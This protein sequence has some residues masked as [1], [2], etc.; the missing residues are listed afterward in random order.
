M[1][2]TINILEVASE[3]AHEKLIKYSD[4]LTEYD[5]RNEFPNGVEV[6]EY[7]IITYTEEAQEVFNQFYDEYYDF[8]C[9]FKENN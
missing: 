7:D 5:Y 8:L 1:N 2:I 9:K 4:D 3:L 6:E